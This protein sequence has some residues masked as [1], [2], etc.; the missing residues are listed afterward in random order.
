[1]QPWRNREWDRVLTVLDLRWR[2]AEAFA[3]GTEQGEQDDGEGVEQQ[4]PVAPLGVGDANCAEAQAEAQVL[5]VAEA[6]LH[7]STASSRA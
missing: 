3:G 2:H 7:S 1:M 6:G 5:G 4:Q